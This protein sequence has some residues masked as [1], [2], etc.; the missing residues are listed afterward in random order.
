MFDY[1]KSQTLNIGVDTEIPPR[2][3]YLKQGECAVMMK[4][5]IDYSNDLAIEF[6][7]LTVVE[8]HPS[9][10]QA[11]G[12]CEQ[13]GNEELIVCSPLGISIYFGCKYRSS[14]DY[15]THDQTKRDI[16]DEVRSIMFDI[17]NHRKGRK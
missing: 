17:D 8:A 10:W 15:I 3:S 6:I 4:V 7:Q 9:A 1:Q 16:S 5:N 12:F 13:I 11:I 2:V 14:G